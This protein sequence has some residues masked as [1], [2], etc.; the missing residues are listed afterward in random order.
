[1]VGKIITMKTITIKLVLLL[2]ISAS[3]FAQQQN[4]TM[5]LK[6]LCAHRGGM[7]THPE[8]TIPAFRY[9][10][11]S[12][13]QM[14][15]FDIQFSKD[16]VLV[17]MHDDS[18]DR[19]TD[20]KGNVAD[21]T[22]KQLKQLDA[23]I[24]KGEQFKGTKIPTL[25]ETL[26]VMPKNIW[27]NCHLKG[28]R[29]L[30]KAVATAIIKSGRITQC[31]L[32]CDEAAAAAARKESS[33]IIICNADNRYRQDNAKY[34]LATINQKAKFL[35]LLAIGDAEQRKPLIRQLKDNKVLINFFYAA[36][37]A[38]A[39]PLWQEGIDFI[40]VNNLPLFVPEMEKAGIKKVNAI[41]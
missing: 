16:S 7:D 22:L 4:F 23:G 27:L 40:L 33:A 12:G 34:V 37:A 20:G 3:G 2:I 28:G 39:A 26:A 29:E 25:E 41:F 8:N 36:R 24:K 31:L 9:S 15:E 1:M 38:D 10:I 21:L 30:G 14:I 32:A 6:G 35:Q 17:I 19:T 13:V 11:E 5:P 18:V